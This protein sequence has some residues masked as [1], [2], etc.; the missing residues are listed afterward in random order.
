MPDVHHFRTFCCVA[1][2]KETK[3]NLKKLDNRGTPVVFIGY[4]PGAKAWRFYNPA[5]RR[6]VVSRDAVFNEPAAWTWEDEDMSSAADFAF[7]HHVL[8]QE[9]VQYTLDPAPRSASPSPGPGTPAGGTPV[10]SPAV[11]APSTPT[12]PESPLA[13]PE[14]V[15]PPPDAEDHLDA[16]ADDVEP[17]YRTVD[18]VIGAATPPGFAMRQIA[19]ELHLQLEEEPASFV[20]AEKHAC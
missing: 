19:A 9:A 5:S 3:P 7:E 4:E 20:E 11:P 10:Q 16:D 14:F 18:N 6:A 15:S 17:R 2:I 1:F 13:T 12:P 8:E